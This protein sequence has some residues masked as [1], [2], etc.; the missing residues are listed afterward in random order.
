[1]VLRNW[2]RWM[3]RCVAVQMNPPDASVLVRGFYLLTAR[4]MDSSPDAAFRTSMLDGQPT[5]ETVYAYQKGIGIK[6]KLK[7]DQ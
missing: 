4:W 3:A 2:P 7:K 5:L 1:M 6:K